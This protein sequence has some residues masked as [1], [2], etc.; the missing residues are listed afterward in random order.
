MVM[1][2]NLKI[3]YADLLRIVNEKKEIYYGDLVRIVN[4]QK[5]NNYNAIL[6][7]NVNGKNE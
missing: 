7:R 3:Y 2:V 5:I 6:I 4:K 1:I